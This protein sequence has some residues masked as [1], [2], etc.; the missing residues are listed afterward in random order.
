[1]SAGDDST[2]PVPLWVK[3]VIVL[4]ALPVLCA[5]LL[6]AGVSPEGEALWLMRLYPAAIVLAAVC[7][8]RAYPQRPELSW[9]LIILML[10]IHASMWVLCNNSAA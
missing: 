6:S 1:M 7:A 2:T 8:W 3:I 5:P 9:I 10:L 4:A